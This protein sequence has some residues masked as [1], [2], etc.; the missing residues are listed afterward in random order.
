MRAFVARSNHLTDKDRV[1]L[2]NVF[3]KL[4]S[5]C[6][7]RS[8]YVNLVI[9]TSNYFFFRRHQEH[10]PGV[11]LIEAARQA[12]YAHYHHHSRWTRAQAAFTIESLNVD[13]HNFINPNYPVRIRVEEKGAD[14]IRRPAKRW[15]ALPPSISGIS[16]RL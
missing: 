2:S 9:D 7:P 1:T 13:F 8:L 12:I 4:P 5:F 11:M 15:R 6:R 3:D 16:W 14:E 10:V